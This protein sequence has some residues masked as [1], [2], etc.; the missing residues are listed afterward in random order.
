MPTIP[1]PTFRDYLRVL[2]ERRFLIL[3]PVVIAAAAAFFY[4]AAQPEEYEAS[5]AISFQA[6]S[7]DLQ[8][9]GTPVGADA[10]PEKQ[11]A[12]GARRITENKV[13]LA[14]QEAIGDQLSAEELRA[15]VTTQVEPDSNLVRITATAPTAADAARLA[16]EFARQTRNYLNVEERA[17]FEAAADKLNAELKKLGEDAAA[18]PTG[19]SYREGISRLLTLASLAEAVEVVQLAQ[20]PTLP[21]SPK[22]IRDTILAAFL[23]LLLGLIAAFLRHAVD[24]RLRDPHEVQ[25]DLNLPV[26]GQVRSGLMGRVRLDG[27]GGRLDEEDLDAFRVL[28]TNFEF[29]AAEP[30]LR[31]VVVTSALAEEGKSTVAAGFAYA[32][33]VAGR[34]TLLIECDLR[35]PVLAERLGLVQG[36]GLS[37]ALGGTAELAE[38]V[39]SIEVEGGV[40]DCVPAGDNVFHPSEMLGSK[41]FKDFLTKTLD[42]YELVVIDS[43]PL[44]PVS[45]TLQLLPQV[46][47]A[48]LCV[49]MR[50]TTRDQALS[51]KVA[52]SQL[53][54]LAV[55]LVV[56]DLKAKHGYYGG[57][58]SYDRPP[59]ESTNTGG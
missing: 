17:K 15:S 42:V 47:A 6:E 34:R 54:D 23:G 52:T 10:F 21:S 56:T 2:R 33:A 8:A 19:Q 7:Q 20:V 24:R 25:R 50:R 18:T 36:P 44:L 58:Y 4:S 5:A 55:G 28:R 22:P 46:D 37:E 51:A 11:A 27:P 53:P 31:S 35:R 45:D 59:A 12:S 40:L 38:V 29:L 26:I 14:V 48:L 30:E 57:Y 16:N 41:R 39:Q 9:V 32:S 43:A 13:V 1:A 3:L 49:R